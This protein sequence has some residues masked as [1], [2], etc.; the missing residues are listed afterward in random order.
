MLLHESRRAARRHRDGELVLLAE[1]DRSRWDREQIAEGLALVRA[2]ARLPGNRP[3]YPASRHCGT[4][5]RGSDT[6]GNRLD[7]IV[8]LYDVLLRA[9]RPRGRAQPGGGIA[10]GGMGPRGGSS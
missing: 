1:Q 5:R 7:E 9:D 2:G 8:G 4:A 3:L 6:R 10:M